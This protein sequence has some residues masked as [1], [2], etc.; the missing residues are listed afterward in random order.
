M[1]NG[2]LRVGL[3]AGTWALI[4]ALPSFPI[5][6]LSNL[7]IDFS[8]TH[9]VDMWPMELGLPGLVAGLLF[10]ALLGLTGQF[11][12]FEMLPVARLAGLGAVAGLL[13]G[14]IYVA[15]V[16]PEPG[17]IIALIFAL[18][19]PL[20]AI[21]GPGSALVFRMLARSR[22]RVEARA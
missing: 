5:E 14:G 22:G 6:G 15:T 1:T 12:R 11:R 7:G 17:R 3:L 13:V 16:W 4:Y 10:A 19:V 8:F 20:G 21:A 9:A 18:A 2:L